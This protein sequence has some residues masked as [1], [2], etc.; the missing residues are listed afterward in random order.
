MCIQGAY[1]SAKHE[2]TDQ[3]LIE[4]TCAG[5][6]E[7]FEILVDRY[8][9]ILHH[10]VKG[11]IGSELAEDVVQHVMLKLYMHIDKLKLAPE[12]EW[13]DQ[14]LKAWLFQVAWNRCID[15]LRKNRKHPILFSELAA[16][17]EEEDSSVIHTLLDPNPQPEELAEVHDEQ[18]TIYAAIKTLPPKFRAVVWL[19]YK[20]DLTFTEIG[21]RLNMPMSTAKTYFHRARMRLRTTLSS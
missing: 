3:Y 13:K 4:Q 19:H 5:H 10:F 17:K 8:Q 7:A 2:L 21:N 6:Q 18:S 20:E 11:Y 14:S 16:S 1:S 15:E 9:H 12:S